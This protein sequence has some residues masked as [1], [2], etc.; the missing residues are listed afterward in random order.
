MQ[1]VLKPIQWF[2]SRL[3]YDK[4]ILFLIFYQ[5][6]HIKNNQKLKIEYYNIPGNPILFF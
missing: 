1:I 2:N 3:L 5:G 6:N 4:I